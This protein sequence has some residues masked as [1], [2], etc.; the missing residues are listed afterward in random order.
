MHYSLSVSLREAQSWARRLTQ[1]DYTY[2]VTSDL[3]DPL[4]LSSCRW[5]AGLSQSSSVVRGSGLVHHGPWCQVRVPEFDSPR[6][7]FTTNRDRLSLLS[8]SNRLSLSCLTEPDLFK[9]FFS[10]IFSWRFF[11][12]RTVVHHAVLCQVWV[13]G[14]SSGEDQ[15]HWSGNTKLSSKIKILLLFKLKIFFN[16]QFKINLNCS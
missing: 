6:S 3:S 12:E 11:R 13:C 9:L 2:T 5:T 10:L 7:K 1:G 4:S 14:L 16:T 15:L 8:G